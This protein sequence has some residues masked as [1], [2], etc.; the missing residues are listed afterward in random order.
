MY[1]CASSTVASVV[2]HHCNPKNCITVHVL[3]YFVNYELIYSTRYDSFIHLPP[4]FNA[5][6]MCVCVCVCVM[7]CA[8]DGLR[9]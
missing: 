9:R 8:D 6:M 5:E 7:D 2:L 1:L 4:R 3:Y